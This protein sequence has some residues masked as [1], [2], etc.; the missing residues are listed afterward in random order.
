LP[1]APTTELA[2]AARPHAVY[3]DSRVEPIESAEAAAPAVSAYARTG[4]DRPAAGFINGRGL[5]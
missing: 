1:A 2:A 4:Y 5:Y 3:R